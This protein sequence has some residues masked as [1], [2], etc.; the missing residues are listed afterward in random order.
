[1]RLPYKTR[2]ARYIVVHGRMLF[3]K[4]TRNRATGPAQRAAARSSA[5]SRHKY[6]DVRG[7]V[8]GGLDRRSAALMA[9]SVDMLGDAL[10][11]VLSLFALDR[12]ERWRAGTALVK[13]ITILAFGI[14][15]LVEV[16]AKFHPHPG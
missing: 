4:T 5:G 9:D 1:M 3:R 6:H 8:H 10:V 15:V 16:A 2:N 13:G 12:S 7:R 11:Y 14:G